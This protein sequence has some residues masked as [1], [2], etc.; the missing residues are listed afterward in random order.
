VG[1]AVPGAPRS[2]GEV[3]LRLLRRL[4]RAR[5]DDPALFVDGD[6]RPVAAAGGRAAHV[7][8]FARTLGE[9]PGA[10]A[11]VAVAPRLVLGLRGDGG[12]PVGAC[13][14]DTRLALPGH[15]ASAR[16]T[17]LVTGRAAG[18]AP[19]GTVR[20]AELLWAAPVALL[21]AGRR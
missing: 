3:K 9:G 4:L 1:A 11:V 10:R 20:L 7:V 8:A 15:L 13:W 2:A 5:R 6:Y 19:D 18:V 14:D 17:E 16:W 21:A 12:P